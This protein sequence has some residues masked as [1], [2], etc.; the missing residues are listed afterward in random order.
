MLAQLLSGGA[1]GFLG[2]ALDKIFPNPE[3]KAKA[4]A[5]LIQAASEGRINELSADMEVMLAEAKSADKWTSRARPSFLYVIYLMILMAVPMGVVAAI[6]PD[7][8]THIAAG[9]QAWL[10]AIPDALWTLFGAGYLGYT[11]AREYGKKRLL[12]SLQNVGRPTK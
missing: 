7:L 5:A 12:D 9:M 8:A 1:F 2:K 10:A 6:N 11:G 4:E 3:D